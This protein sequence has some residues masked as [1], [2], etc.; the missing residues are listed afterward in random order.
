M[1]QRGGSDDSGIAYGAM[2]VALYLIIGVLI[3][4][5]WT[6][7][8]DLVLGSTIN[9]MIAAGQVSEQTAAAT[10][11]DVNFIRYAPP[12]MLLFGFCFAI[13][14]AI[15]RS[16]GGPTTFSTFWWGFVA[17]LL[18]CVVGLILTF[19]GGYLIDYIHE[20]SASWPGQDSNFANDS[21]WT[22][23]W[24]INCYYFVCYCIPVLGAIIFGQSLVKR[25]RMSGYTR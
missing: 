23:Y 14:W 4:L 9:P 7:A 21:L 3:W 18:F 11:W 10:A 6:Y 15:Y 17:F 1:I 2:M 16:G 8:Y 5:S 22:V 12:I 19:F 24:F 13:N 25:V 20:D